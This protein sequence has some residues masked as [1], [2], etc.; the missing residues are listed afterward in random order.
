MKL[1]EVA[2]HAGVSLAT[3][4]RVINGSSRTPA[5]EIAERVKAAAAEL[6]YVANAQAQALA[7]QSTGLVGLVVHDIADP[8][9]STIAHGVQ[10]A[11]LAANHQVLL[12]GTDLEHDGDSPGDAELA[13]VNAFISYRTDAIIL[14][15]SRL[16]EEDPRLSKA[17]AQYISNGGRVVTIGTTEIPDARVLHVDNHDGAGALVQA[18]TARGQRRFVILAGPAERN[19][20]RIRV[21]GFTDRLQEAGLAPVAVVHGE[22]TSQG[23]FDSTLEFL[24][25]PTAGALTDGSGAATG[26]SAYK[27]GGSE[28]TDSAGPLC[29]LAA[30]DVMALGAMAALRTRGLR[31][32]EDVQV[33]G[34]D[35]IPTLR[36]H[37]PGLTTYRL[38]LEEMGQIAAQLALV[39]DAKTPTSVTGQVVLRESAGGN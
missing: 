4:S 32:P 14:A 37:F 15:A 30:N 16:L 23:G 18:L 28:D 33:A 1:S 11:A 6:G 34:F 9:F 7:R 10:Q 19:T 26:G 29:I 17:L 3:A 22:F 2:R 31:I 35:D 27:G 38:P 12:A 39:P 5:A 24:D 20:A 8:Y 36:D 25:G 21:T 13:A